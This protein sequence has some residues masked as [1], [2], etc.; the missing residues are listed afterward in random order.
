MFTCGKVGWPKEK[1]LFQ[2]PRRGHNIPKLCFTLVFTILSLYFM[3]CFEPSKG[4]SNQ[5]IVF[6]SIPE[7]PPMMVMQMIPG[8]LG[9]K[10]SMKMTSVF[11][12]LGEECQTRRSLTQ[13]A[14]SSCGTS[15][16]CFMSQA[17]LDAVSGTA[18]FK[19]SEHLSHDGLSLVT[20]EDFCFV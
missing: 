10:G 14:W 3:A 11:S 6:L 2:R 1:A 9:R 17:Q 8:S 12:S 7:A 16:R 13:R 19:M 18:C 20:T 4:S 5:R 15:S